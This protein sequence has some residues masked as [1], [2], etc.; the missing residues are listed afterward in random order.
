MAYLF[1]ILLLLS[2]FAMILG[3][4]KPGLVLHWGKKRTR[5]KAF[6]T[7][8]ASAIICFVLFGIITD[9]EKKEPINIAGKSIE[10]D[11][12]SIDTTLIK[13]IKPIAKNDGKIENDKELI[14]AANT[15]EIK[16]ITESEKKI[17]KKEQ[18]RIDQLKKQ[19]KA[20]LELEQEIFTVEKTATNSKENFQHIINL[21][22]QNEVSIYEAYK[23]ANFAKEQCRDVQYRLHKI[24]VTKEIPKAERKLLQQA[25]LEI[26]TA[27]M[28]QAEAFDE[29]KKYLDENKMSYQLNYQKKMKSSDSFIITAITKIAQAKEKMG[30]DIL[31]NE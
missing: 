9:S 8:F 19:Q 18:K 4:M 29:L 26:S 14:R 25:I 11:S 31:K 21:F 30:M 28:I 6:L 7:Y 24:K 12:A 20:V 23:A 27:Y 5:M 16:T 17:S 13:D 22:K 10:K 2:I 1:L 3:I 15:E